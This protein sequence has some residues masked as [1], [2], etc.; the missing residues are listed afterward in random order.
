MFQAEFADRLTA[1]V[2]TK[3]YGALTL[4][5]QYHARITRLLHVPKEAFSPRPKV[6][7]AVLRLDLCS[8]YQGTCR[9]EISLTRLV[10]I[11][12]SFRRKTLT[13]ALSH[14]LPGLSRDEILKALA[15][16]GLE[17]GVRAETLDIEEFIRLSEA[18]HPFLTK[19][20][21]SDS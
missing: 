19:I 21:M 13:N 3:A 14:G 10:K 4:F 7:S 2:G 9:S 17:P 8:P 12:F 5:A 16:C 15:A 18:F 20:D 11:C 6:D 1:R